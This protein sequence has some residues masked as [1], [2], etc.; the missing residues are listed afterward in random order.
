V[1]SAAG[2][3][4]NFHSLPGIGSTFWVVMKL[5]YA[6][7]PMP[8]EPVDPALEGKVVRIDVRSEVLQRSILNYCLAMGLQ[9]A[10]NQM[11]PVDLAIADLDS[12]CD[13]KPR[14][15]ISGKSRSDN[16]CIAKPVRYAE[17]LGAVKGALARASVAKCS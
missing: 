10:A 13:D 5:G 17:L 3:S 2:G 16:D 8:P 6:R 15:L 14:V 7:M 1:V 4:L 11:M 9:P 12:K